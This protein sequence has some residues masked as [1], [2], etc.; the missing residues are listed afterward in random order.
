MKVRIPENINL[1]A[2]ITEHQI[3]F[4]GFKLEKVYLVLSAIRDNM[5]KLNRK[6][7][8]HKR[9]GKP[10]YVPL[11][12][13][14]LIYY[15]GTEYYKNIIS[16]MIKAGLIEC[17]GVYGRRITSLGYK[18]ADKYLRARFTTIEIKDKVLLKKSHRHLLA[19]D[20][21]Q[22]PSETVQGLVARFNGNRLTVDADAAKEYIE[23]LYIKDEAKANRNTKNR[24]FELTKAA[25]KRNNYLLLV[26]YLV[27]EQY[28]YIQDKQGR[29]HTVLT[30]MPKVLRGYIRID[31]QTPVQVDMSNSQLF[32]TLYLLNLGNYN[33]VGMEKTNQ[34][35]WYGCTTSRS[36]VYNT[37]KS[38][39]FF[40]HGPQIPKPA[41]VF[42]YE[43]SQ[44]LIYS[45]M[46]TALE[47]NQVFPKSMNALRRRKWVKDSLLRQVYAEP[48]SKKGTFSTRKGIMEVV[49]H[50]KL[51]LGNKG[52]LWD[53]FCK[54]YEMV[55]KVYAFIRK[56]GYKML[57][58]VLQRIESH[59]IIECVCKRILNE[60]PYVPIYTIH[61]CL[62][63][64]P[65]HIDLVEGIMKEEI[66]IFV[67]EE[68]SVART[69]WI[70]HLPE[71]EIQV[72]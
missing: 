26:D 62:V 48:E 13:D 65:Q 33:R 23:G 59:A 17:D 58:R 56:D 68:P 11:R 16:W 60:Y 61:D 41:L 47:N 14:I 31:S 46:V 54:R 8:K 57:A 36:S 28:P 39:V 45:R 52:L 63:T 18:L 37:I 25:Q 40:K 27:N 10:F 55:A 5:V 53:A 21:Q 30:R 1:S 34:F 71:P 4:S 20:D 32:F 22:E 15:L 67:G 24:D 3:T 49:K 51:Y 66:R 64:V 19:T 43:A 44:G 35:I 7:F 6:T 38:S 50:Q 9:K 42:A 29:L 70:E 69:S 12:S 72:A 2:L